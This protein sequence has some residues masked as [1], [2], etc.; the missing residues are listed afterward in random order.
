[1]N[2]SW[3]ERRHHRERMIQKRV[4][5]VRHVWYSTRAESPEQDGLI[6]GHWPGELDKYNLKCSCSMCTLPRYDRDAT[7]REARRLVSEAIES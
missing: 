4:G 6:A 2:R 5:I 7:K 1:M 3:P